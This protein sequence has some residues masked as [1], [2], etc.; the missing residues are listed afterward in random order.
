MARKSRKHLDSAP[1]ETAPSPVCYNAAA[2]LRLSIDD[3]KKRGDSIETQKNIIENYVATAPGIRII[4]TYTDIDA[5][6]TNFERPG[7]QRMLAD[8]QCGRVNCIIVKDISRFGRNAIDGGYYLEKHLPSLGVRFIAV[9]D[10]YDSNEPENGMLLPLMNII[11]ESYALDIGRKVKAVH[12]RN[13]ADGRYVGRLAPYGYR[14]APEDCHRL[15]PDAETAPVVRQIFEW[16]YD[17]VS[18]QEIAKRLIGAGY[19]T[20]SQHNHAKGYDKAYK[21]ATPFWQ[22]R[23]I[24]GILADRV[25]VGDM[26]QGKTKTVCG[27]QIKLD[28]SEWVCVPNTHEPLVSRELFNHVQSLQLKI[29]ERAKAIHGNIEPYSPN[30]LKGKVL[31]GRC[32]RLMHRH[33]QNKDGIY[34]FRCESQVK[35][36]KPAC[37]VVS[38]KEAELNAEIMATLRGQTGA[39]ADRHAGLDKGVAEL[40]SASSAAEMELRE[41]NREL[42]N[43]GR[44]LKSLYE[45]LVNEIITPD[46]YTQ[47]KS[48]YEDKIRALSLRADDL[49]SQIRRLEE[50][51]NEYGGFAGA[52]SAA[53]HDGRLTADMADALIE[54]IIV[55]P[56]KSFE[57]FCRFDNGFGEVG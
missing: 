47:M 52:V 30:A 35:Y 56:D 53:I 50:E 41:T 12:Q 27:K 24:K 55:M 10:Q 48:G 1:V 33:R 2:Y 22:P 9:T 49:R 37:T 29:F 25:Y 44:F 8:A 40:K 18:A 42:N 3:T 13:I 32:G 4:D 21:S 39:I 38:V 46:E 34:W 23:T 26:V 19:P 20:P 28:P 6:G 11:N 16:A 14:K 45:S 31:C 15:V 57:V 54:K 7:F 5:T 51:R 17:D 36:G 43:T